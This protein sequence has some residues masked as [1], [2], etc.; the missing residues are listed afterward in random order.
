MNISIQYRKQWHHYKIICT[1]QRRLIFSHLHQQL[2]C[3]YFINLNSFSSWWNI[4][5][6][7]WKTRN[8][9]SR[10]HAFFLL[11]KLHRKKE[12]Q[13]R[14]ENKYIAKGLPVILDFFHHSVLQRTHV[15][16]IGDNSA[17]RWGCGRHLL[18]LKNLDLGCRGSNS[19]DV[20]SPSNHRMNR[21]TLSETLRS[22]QHQTTDK[23]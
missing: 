11:N 1:I 10:E 18:P 13:T 2:R 21:E 19:A 15:A 7:I 3:I 5:T 23:V 9:F 4:T 12:R 14:E 22:W 6:S 20:L 17:L 16:E 8:L